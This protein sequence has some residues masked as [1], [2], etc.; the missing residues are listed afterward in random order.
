MFSWKLKLF[1]ATLEQGAT[2]PTRLQ[3]VYIENPY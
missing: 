3:A 2:S 1:N